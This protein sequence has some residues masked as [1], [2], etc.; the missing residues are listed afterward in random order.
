MEPAWAFASPLEPESTVEIQEV[1]E[2]E[3]PPSVDVTEGAA[4]A[5]GPQGAQEPVS[6]PDNVDQEDEEEEEEEA[7]PDAGD[8]LGSWTNSSAD[9]PTNSSA[10]SWNEIGQV[11]GF[12][13]NGE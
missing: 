5:I 9:G 12:L 11:L 2:Q 4:D 10:D 6:D 1:F 8:S 3:P 13:P 7:A